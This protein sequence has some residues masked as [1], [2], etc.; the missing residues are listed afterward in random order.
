MTDQTNP[1]FPARP[2]TEWDS[3]PDKARLEMAVHQAGARNDGGDHPGWAKT[4]R[5]SECGGHGFI[6]LTDDGEQVLKSGR[7]KFW[8][9]CDGCGHRRANSFH[10]SPHPLPGLSRQRRQKVSE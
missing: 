9:R 6:R 3:D 7:V 2:W 5:C 10:P 1:E 4:R 8:E